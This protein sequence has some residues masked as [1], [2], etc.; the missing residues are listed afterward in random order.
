MDDSLLLGLWRYTLPVP[1]L[2]WQRLVKA[3]TDLGFMSQDHHQVR[4]FVVTELPRVGRPLSPQTIA[5]GLNL[6][7][8]QVVD[9]LDELERH[10][11]FLFRNE[12]GDVAWAYPVTVDRTPHHVTLSTGERAYAA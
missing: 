6:P 9:M 4:D 7:P 5:Q 12:Q 8:A 2:V 3:D 1:R 10:M 11:T